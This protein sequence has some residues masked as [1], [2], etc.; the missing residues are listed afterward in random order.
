MKSTLFIFIVAL[1]AAFSACGVQRDSE[2]KSFIADMD[3]VAIDIERTVNEKPDTGVDRAQQ[4]LDAR[5]PEL[6][7]KFESL[8]E[9]RGYQLSEATTKEFTD[10]VAR[11]V[12]KVGDLQIKYAEKSVD[13]EKFGQ[14]LSKLSDDFNSIFGV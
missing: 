2:V 5:K 8:K 6:K 11:N 10:A 12:E 13:D 4:M 14:K 3:Q 7:K 1:A 9:L